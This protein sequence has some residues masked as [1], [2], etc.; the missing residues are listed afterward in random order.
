MTDGDTTG[1]PAPRKPS[2][3]DVTWRRHNLSAAVVMVI[4]A[5]G[6]LTTSLLQ[7]GPDAMKSTHAPGDASIPLHGEKASQAVL[8]LDPNTATAAQLQLLPEVGPITARKII[9]TREAQQRN[10]IDRPFRR[11]SDLNKVPGIGDKTIR[12]FAEHLELPE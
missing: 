3:L 1:P 6:L 12:R 10:G 4:L 2:R 8:R 5:A 9:D 7:R 11:L